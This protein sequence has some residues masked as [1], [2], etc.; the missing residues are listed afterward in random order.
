[1]ENL[2]FYFEV[3]SYAMYSF[4][5]GAIVSKCISFLEKQWLI[6]C[7]KPPLIMGHTLGVFH[8]ICFIET[9][10]FFELGSKVVL[11]GCLWI[12]P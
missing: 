10:T 8:F 3:E 7:L 9:L 2:E 11:H 1:M 12:W 5:S 4:V 6:V